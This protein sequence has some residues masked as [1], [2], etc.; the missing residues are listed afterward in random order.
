VEPAWSVERIAHQ[1][2]LR[3]H[4]LVRKRKRGQEEQQQEAD[5]HRLEVSSVDRNVLI[6]P[7]RVARYARSLLGE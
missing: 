6:V 2:G 7:H 5:D 1:H 4:G 3:R